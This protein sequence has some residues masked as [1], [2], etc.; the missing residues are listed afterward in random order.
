MPNLSASP[1]SRKVSRSS[2]R[3]GILVP[4]RADRSSEPAEYAVGR[5][6]SIPEALTIGLNPLALYRGRFFDADRGVSVTLER[7]NDPVTVTIQQSYEG[8]KFKDFTDQFKEHPGQG[9]LHYGTNLRY[10][11]VL[12]TDLARDAICVTT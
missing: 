5:T 6:E 12:T 2:A 4:V 9:Y 8:L 7:A 10:K 11:L 3:E 1:A